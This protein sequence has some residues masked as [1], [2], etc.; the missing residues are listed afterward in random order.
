MK[1]D[2][3]EI[4]SLLADPSFRF[5]AEKLVIKCGVHA[6]HKGCQALID[7]VILCGTEHCRGVY[8]AYNMIAEARGLKTKT[9]MREIYYALSQAFNLSDN[10]YKLIGVKVPEKEITAG[11]LISYLSRLFRNPSLAVYS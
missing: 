5:T 11:L 1:Y 8:P 3:E 2:T 10:L 7:A 4:L 6:D 9:V